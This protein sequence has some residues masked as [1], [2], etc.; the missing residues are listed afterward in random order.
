MVVKAKK[1]KGTFRNIKYPAILQEKADG[2][3]REVH[4]SING[5][6]INTRQGEPSTMPLIKEQYENDCFI[7]GHY[8]GELLVLLNQETYDLVLP[9]LL[10]KKDKSDVIENLTKDLEKGVGVMPRSIGNGLINSDRCP[11]DHVYM[12]VWEYVS[13]EEYKNAVN[14][15]KNT[16]DYSSRI[17]LLDAMVNEN[18][19]DKISV[20]NG[21]TV[22]N[23]KEAMEQTSKWMHLGL[24]GSIIKNFEMVYKDGTNLEQLKMKLEISLD[25]RIKGFVEGNKGSKNE[26]YFSSILFENDEG[27][28][29]G[30]FGVTSLT[31][32]ERDWFNDNRE[33]VTGRVVEIECNDITQGSGNDYYALSHPR[34]I[35]LR[36][37]EETDDLVRAMENKEMAMSLS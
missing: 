16:T 35:T 29:K 14:R 34:Y 17:S 19:S 8:F 18:N 13:D 5:V 22:N 12:D 32:E 15:K 6:N 26:D 28:I 21:I 24:E 11:H 1:V 31:E 23:A 2:T 9:K 37:K 4:K 33:L 27:S 3:Y 25:M 30:R 20:I 10:K 36:D 7:N